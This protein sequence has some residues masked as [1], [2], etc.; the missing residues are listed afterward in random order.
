MK[1]FLFPVLMHF[2][3]SLPFG[4]KE[5]FNTPTTNISQFFVTKRPFTFSAAFISMDAPMT[6]NKARMAFFWALPRCLVVSI[7]VSSSK[8]VQ[9]VDMFRDEADSP[10]S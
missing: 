7:Q 5:I 4:Q 6:N 3:Y 8:T 2:S 9:T 1:V 10:N